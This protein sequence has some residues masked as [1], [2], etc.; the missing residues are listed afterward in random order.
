MYPEK[1]FQE[2]K[3]ADNFCL[4]IKKSEYIYINKIGEE[5]YKNIQYTSFI[6]ISEDIL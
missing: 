6:I 5:K 3:M 1:N 2:G 4:N